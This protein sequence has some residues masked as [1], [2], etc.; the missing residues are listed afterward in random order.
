MTINFEKILIS[1]NVSIKEAMKRLDSADEK[2]LFVIDDKKALLGSLTDG[3]IRRWILK[4][5]SINEKV[6]EVCYKETY[7]VNVGYEIDEVKSKILKL[8]INYV[9][10]ID[11]NR[12]I[13]EFLVWDMLFDGKIRR[14]TRKSLKIPIIIMAGGKGTRLDPFT[15]I[16]PKSLIPIG[17]KTILEKII[18]KFLTYQINHFYISVNH[19]ANIIKSYFKELDPDY[20]ITYLYEEK[21]LGTIGAL[22]QLYG[23]IEGDFI[24][25]NCD[26]IIEA[27]YVDILNQ[28][29]NN[30]NDITLVVS[31]KH[32]N[33]PYGICEIDN[34]GNLVTI[35]EKPGY[36]FLVNTGMYI[37]NS[38]MLKYIPTNE[39]F[40][41][42]HLI[43]IATKLG[44][45]I[46][47]YPISENS[48]IDIGEWSEYKNTIEKLML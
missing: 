19:K 25:T 29:K 43:E 20:K 3:D 27:D 18:E 40:H 1:D 9:P 41:I 45:K 13:I 21:P 24:L 23:Q 37:L 12:R 48:W 30:R 42:T 35:L 14:K 32:F 16:L 47:V 8:N 39:F 36:D 33:I 28:H 22:K 4:E 17:D 46:S 5:G 44:K 26:I 10:V 2:I 38:E 31:L 15:R 11:S 7:S 6:K 34:S